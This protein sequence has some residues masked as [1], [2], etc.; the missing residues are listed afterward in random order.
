MP[1]VVDQLAALTA[2][3]D[4]DAVD[5][6]LA[7]AMRE[8][9]RPTLVV[10]S[11]CVGEE[12][13]RRW[14]TRALLRPD[15]AVPGADPL[16]TQLQ[17]LPVLAAHPARLAA[18]ERQAPVCAPGAPAVTVFPLAT[19][20]AVVGVLELHTERPLDADAM[21]LVCSILRVHRNFTGLLDD[22]ERDTLT[23]L[24]N[25]KTFDVAFYKL[26]VSQDLAPGQ[27][28]TPDGERRDGIGD[29]QQH[30]I[31]V[32]D[33]D[34]FKAVND[35][36]GHLIGDEVLL[37][38][39]R[40][41]R[42]AFRFNDRLFRFGGEEF[43]VL[44]RCSGDAQAG[45]ALERMRCLVKG[46]AFPQVGTISVSVGFTQVQPGDTP[47]AAFERADRAVYWAKAHGRDQVCSHAALVARGDLAD[48]GKKVGDVELF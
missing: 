19:D 41:M 21:R 28:G 24:L 38:L 11:R 10:V 8:L 29:G 45:V 22:S 35:A 14:L 25:R 32:I 4:R 3:R 1:S 27:V 47:S 36:H 30:Y 5:V 48:N 9:L 39:A 42:S 46:F 13:D 23:G 12:P 17:D 43:V 2:Y 15:D 20:R 16:W 7:T 40:L 33:I 34:H 6:S 18:L 37:L 44:M 31:G 26:A